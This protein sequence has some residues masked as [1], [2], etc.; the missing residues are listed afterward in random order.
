VQL[1]SNSMVSS[2][3]L[4]YAEKSLTQSAYTADQYKVY[5]LSIGFMITHDSILDTRAILQFEEDSSGDVY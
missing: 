4:D 3:E 5:G 1:Y 2:T